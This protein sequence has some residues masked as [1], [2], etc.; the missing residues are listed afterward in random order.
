MIL[1]IFTLLVSIV[2]IDGAVIGSRIQDQTGIVQ[3]FLSYKSSIGLPLS[4]KG[5][6]GLLV[7][8]RKWNSSEPNEF[9]CDPVTP[10]R[11]RVISG[12]PWVLLI[13]RGY[14]EF[15]E[16]LINAEKAGYELVIVYN[17][18]DDRLIPMNG[19]A[20]PEVKAVFVGLST[21]ETLKSNYLYSVNPSALVTLTPY[22]TLPWHMYI[23]PFLIVISI[24]FLLMFIFLVI[25]KVRR[26]QRR[27]RARLPASKLKKLKILIYSE[28]DEYDMCAIC[29]DDFEDG[30]KLRILPCNHG[31]HSHC[32]DPWLTKSRRVCPCCKQAVFP[33]EKVPVTPPSPEVPAPLLSSSNSYDSS[34]EP[35]NLAPNITDSPDEHTPLVR[36]V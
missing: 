35:H 25:K 6:E 14:C 12:Y 27:R 19:D 8:S 33:D 7:L 23:V 18:Q 32:I 26:Y 28:V 36:H 3:T 24:C 13:R 22:Y 20:D 11:S 5:E 4:R 1:S 30:D 29:L 17:D 16:K 10:V 9:A 34:S 31:F 15:A 21:G 2:A